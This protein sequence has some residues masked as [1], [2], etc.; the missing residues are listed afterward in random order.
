MTTGS[1]DR[2]A[3]RWLPTSIAEA[4]PKKAFARSIDWPGWCAVGKTADLALEAFAGYAAALRRRRG[5]RRR[6]LPARRAT[7][8]SSEYRAAAV[9]TDFGVPSAITDA[10]SAAGRRAAEAERLAR[11][12]EAAWTVFDARRAAAPGR[13]AQGPARRRPRPRQDGR[14]T[15]TKRTGLRP[16]DRAPPARRPTR[17]IAPRSRRCARAV[18]DVLRRPIGRLADRRAGSGPPRYAARRIAWHALDHA[19]EMEDRSEPAS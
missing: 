1:D 3:E 12:V 19:W 5:E 7:R 15:S 9:A 14:A 13:A 4:T 11:L 6:G 8:S 16:R 17:R 10:R 18:L 2:S